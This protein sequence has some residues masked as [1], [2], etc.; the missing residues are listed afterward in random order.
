MSETIQRVARAI[1]AEIG[2]QMG[3][4]SYRG[5]GGHGEDWSASGG[6]IDLEKVAR[7][8]IMAMREVTGEMY[9]GVNRLDKMWKHSNSTEIFQA[10]IDGALHVPRETGAAHGE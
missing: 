8:A 4:I 3:A 10:M 5:P 6:V 7:V 1:K 9:E 2:S